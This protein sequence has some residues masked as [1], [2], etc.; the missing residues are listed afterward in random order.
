MTIQQTSIDA[1]NEIHNLGK[2]QLEVI[3]ALKELKVANNR[4]IAELLDMPINSITPRCLE[5]RDLKIVE[6][7][8]TKV[9]SVTKRKT[10]T[11]RLT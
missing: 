9:D 4:E 11:W 7:A 10:M 6:E 1:F 2:R 8:G 3:S 5:L